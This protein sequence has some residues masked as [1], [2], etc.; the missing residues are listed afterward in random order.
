MVGSL[1]LCWGK[2]VIISADRRVIADLG[3]RRM[4]ESKR[5]RAGKIENVKE[6]QLRSIPEYSTIQRDKTI[7]TRQQIRWLIAFLLLHPSRSVILSL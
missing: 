6:A 5:E 7:K 2:T 4:G 1:V 3:E